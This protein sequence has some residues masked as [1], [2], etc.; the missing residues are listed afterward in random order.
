[1]KVSTWLV[2]I[3]CTLFSECIYAADATPSTQA[4]IQ[5][6]MAG[7]G[8][9]AAAHDVDRFMTA[10]LH[11]PSLVFVVNG[12]V[13]HGW[14]ALHAKQVSWWRNARTGARYHMVGKPEFIALAPGKVL[15]TTTRAARLTLP[16]GKVATRAFVVTAIW[17]KL[18]QGWRIVYGHESWTPPPG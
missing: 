12:E 10:Y 18:P 7:L 14:D 3:A 9:A 1:M 17:E 4:Q 15:T 11:A 13:I 6:V 8:R 2:A 5:A 16:D